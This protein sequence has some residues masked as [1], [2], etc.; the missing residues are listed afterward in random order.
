[1]EAPVDVNR[2]NTQYL[3]K[4]AQEVGFVN[5]RITSSGFLRSIWEQV[6]TPFQGRVIKS[7]KMLR[8]IKN[9]QNYLERF[10]RTHLSRVIPKEYFTE[11][12]LYFEKPKGNEPLPIIRKSSPLV[13]S[14][15]RGDVVAASQSIRCIACGHQFKLMDGIPIMYE[16]HDYDIA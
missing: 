15:C 12:R 2:F 4:I 11:A 8:K 16:P 13:C 6:T 7:K 3:E 1:M 9:I 10:D 14:K 5:V